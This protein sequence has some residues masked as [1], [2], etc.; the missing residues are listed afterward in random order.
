[1]FTKTMVQNGDCRLAFPRYEINFMLPSVIV[2]RPRD[3]HVRSY[4]GAAGGFQE[5]RGNY[6]YQA[7]AFT[8]KKRRYLIEMEFKHFNPVFHVK[9]HIFQCCGLIYFILFF[10]ICRLFVHWCLARGVDWPQCVWKPK[11]DQ[12]QDALHVSLLNGLLMPCPPPPT[13]ILC[14]DF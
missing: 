8:K 6:R 1:M 5:S 3:Q 2:Q 4:F 14:S 11:S 10:M 13:Y 7:V 12:R 9:P